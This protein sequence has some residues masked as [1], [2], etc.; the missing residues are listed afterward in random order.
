MEGTSKSVPGAACQPGFCLLIQLVPVCL[1]SGLKSVPISSLGVEIC[2]NFKYLHTTLSRW[3]LNR[4]KGVTEQPG[5][6]TIP[7]QQLLIAIG[8]LL[9]AGARLG[10]GQ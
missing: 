1:I 9:M 10:A 8:T 3:Q 7:A 5:H 4:I 2:A 6:H